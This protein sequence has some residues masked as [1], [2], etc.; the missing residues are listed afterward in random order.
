LELFPMHTRLD[1][2][3]K[4]SEG[5]EHYKTSAYEAISKA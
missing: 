4:F 5:G 2:G 1:K 3:E